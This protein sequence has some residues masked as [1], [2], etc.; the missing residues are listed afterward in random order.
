MDVLTLGLRLLLLLFE[1]VRERKE[2]GDGYTQAIREVF[3][4]AHRELAMADAARIE[5]EAGHREHPNDDAGFDGE[6]R[7]D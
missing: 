1:L 3:E 4:N 7:R 6:F 5:A 2:R